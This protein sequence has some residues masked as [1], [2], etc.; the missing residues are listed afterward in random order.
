MALEAYSEEQP[1]QAAIRGI[2]DRILQ[3]LDQA[4]A[5]IVLDDDMYQFRRE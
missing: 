3:D 5:A 4:A 1:A 2:V